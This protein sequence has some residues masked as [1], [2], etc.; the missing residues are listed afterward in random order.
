[1]AAA[2]ATEKASRTDTQLR[3]EPQGNFAAV[4]W[5]TRAGASRSGLA[6][7]N[8]PMTGTTPRTTVYPK[9]PFQK[10]TTFSRFSRDR[11]STR[12]NSSHGYISYAVFCLKKKIHD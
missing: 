9:R 11:K 5:L 1:M 7:Q 6:M 3:R 8:R 10:T 4:K 2:S 12:L